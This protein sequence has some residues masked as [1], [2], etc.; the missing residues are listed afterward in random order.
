M[1]ALMK[2][3]AP[4]GRSFKIIKVFRKNIP[5]NH[6]I[7]R[8]H[9]E[10]AVGHTRSVTATLSFGWSCYRFARQATQEVYDLMFVVLR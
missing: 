1:Y 2:T 9:A 7:S 8:D 10:A 4:R 5:D 3:S 6:A